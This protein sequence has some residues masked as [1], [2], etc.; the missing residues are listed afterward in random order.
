MVSSSRNSEE[1]SI[2]AFRINFVHKNEMDDYMKP[3][4][5]HVT[6]VAKKTIQINN[7]PSLLTFMRLTRFFHDR[8]PDR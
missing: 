6:D 3:N 8:T 4:E 2:K 1:N 5:A 7:L